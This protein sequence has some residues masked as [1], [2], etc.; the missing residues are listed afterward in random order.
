ML[1]RR[2]KSIKEEPK[3]TTTKEIAKENSEKTKKKTSK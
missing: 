1:L 3:Q 2:H